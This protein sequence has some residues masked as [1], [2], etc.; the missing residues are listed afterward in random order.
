MAG[1]LS[2][3][4]IHSSIIFMLSEQNGCKAK[5]CLEAVYLT[6]TNLLL[7]LLMRTFFWERRKLRWLMIS[8]LCGYPFL[9]CPFLNSLMSSSFSSI[10]SSRKEVSFSPSLRFLA[11]DFM[12]VNSVVLLYLLSTLLVLKYV[13]ALWLNLL[14]T[15][16]S[17]ILTYCTFDLSGF[18]E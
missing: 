5:F 16:S 12:S 2:C 11:L 14:G 1:C 4:W 13:F 7:I 6:S 10:C 17:L 8:S 9:I 15:I 18:T 3:S